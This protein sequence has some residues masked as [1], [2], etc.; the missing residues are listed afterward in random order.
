[1]SARASV[2]DGLRLSRQRHGLGRVVDRGS[3]VGGTGTPLSKH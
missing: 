2:K 1:M 3:F